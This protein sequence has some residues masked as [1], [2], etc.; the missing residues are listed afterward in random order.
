MCRALKLFA[1]LIALPV[2]SM[3]ARAKENVVCDKARCVNN[4]TKAFWGLTFTPSYKNIYELK[5]LNESASCNEQ[6]ATIASTLPRNTYFRQTLDRSAQTEN[7]IVVHIYEVEEFDDGNPQTTNAQSTTAKYFSSPFKLC[8][9][10]KTRVSKSSFKRVGGVST[11]VL[12]VPFK[13]RGGDIYSD[14]TIGPYISY[15]REVFELLA[16]AGLSQISVSEVGTEDVESKT[17]LTGAF[18]V[19]FAVDRNWDIALLVGLDHLSGGAGDEW[20][21]QDKMW[22]SFAI[23]FNFAR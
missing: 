23:G 5:L 22:V 14:S 15:K 3:E 1:L 7:E 18:G 11:G 8:L 2:I 6:D 4:E 10:G 12:V 17:G 13:L 9:N 19:N 20:K 16:T 21:Y